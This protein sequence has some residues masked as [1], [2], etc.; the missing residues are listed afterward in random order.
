MD[1]ACTAFARASG[2][3][4]K[5]KGIFHTFT[6][7]FSSLVSLS[8]DT[9]ERDEFKAVVLEFFR[10]SGSRILRGF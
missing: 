8:V 6:L 7:H 10:R 4:P 3:S 5:P 1:T 9:L 2:R